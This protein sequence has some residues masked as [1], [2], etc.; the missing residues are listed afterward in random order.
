MRTYNFCFIVYLA[1]CIFCV[2]RVKAQDGPNEFNKVPLT[3]NAGAENR[4]QSVPVNLYTGIPSFSVPVYSYSHQ[5]GIGLNVSINYQ[6]GGGVKVNESPSAVGL[7]WRLDAGGSITRVV[8]G[9]PDE[10]YG[11]GFMDAP[12]IPADYRPDGSKYYYDSLDAEQ[13]VFQFNF[14]GRSGKFFIGKNKQIVTVPLS[15]LKITYGPDTAYNDVIGYD[16]SRIGSFCI[17]AEDGTKYLFYD[18]DWG[19]VDAESGTKDGANDVLHATAWYISKIIA[20]FGTDTINF[21]YSNFN[22]YSTILFPKSVQ[23]YNGTVSRAFAPTATQSIFLKK[24]SSITFPDKKIMTFEYDAVIDYDGQD[25]VLKRIKVSDSLFRFGYVLDWTG[26]G[27]TSLCNSNPYNTDNRAFLNGIRY[28]TTTAAK[29]GYSFTYN[30]PKYIH[31]GCT[32]DTLG[33][34]HDHWGF[35]NGIYNSTN[36]I[37]TVAGLYTGANRSPT[38]AAIASSLSSVTDPSG[39]TTNYIYENNDVL[40]YTIA[41]QSFSVNAASATQTSVS[42]SQLFNNL[43]TFKVSFSSTVSRSGAPI[44]SGTGSLI[45]TITSTDGL[46]TY[47]TDTLDLYEMFYTGAVSFSRNINN[48]SYLFKTSLVSGTSAP[49]GLPI[50]VSWSNLS[51]A[52]GNATITGGIR[53]KQVTHVDS[54]TGKVDTIATYRY[55][56]ADGKSS[57]FLGMEPSYNYPYLRTTINLSGT[58]IDTATTT[59]SSEPVSTLVNTQGSPVGYSRVE[60]IKG[61]IYHNLGKQVFEFTNLQDANSSLVQNTFPYVPVQQRDWAMGLPKKISIYDSLGT[62][63]QVTVNTYSYTAQKYNNSSFQCLKLGKSAELKNMI[64]GVFTEYSTGLKYWQESGRADLVTSIDTFFHPNNSTTITRKD[65][66]YDTNYNVS[67]ITTDYDK[68]RSLKLEQRMYY[69]YSYTIG[70]TIGKLRD[71]GIFT[72][73]SKESW[74]T[75]DAT[76]RMLSAS[77]TDLQQLPKKYITPLTIYALQATTPV[78]QSTI[79]T[80]N[81][82]S[83]IRN[84]SYLVA[85]QN[86]VTYDSVGHALEI[87]N[88]LSGQSNA[89]IMDYFNQY[90]VAKVSNARY[91]DIAY[92][93][94]ESD[95]KG[96]WNIPDSPRNKTNAITGKFSYD[97]AKGAI[98]KTGLTTSI[99]YIITYWKATGATVTVSGATGTTL[100]A[101][102]NGWSLYSQTLSGASSVSIS[103]TGLID[104]LRLYPKDANMVTT[105]FEPLVGQTSTCDANSTITY[106]EY[107]GLNRLVV[108]RDKDKNAIKKYAY[109]D[110]AIPNWQNTADPLFCATPADGKAY[111]KQQ[112]INPY[113]ATYGTFRNIVDHTDC[114]MCP[115]PC[116]PSPEIKSVNCVC[117][118][119]IKV[120]TS[121][122]YKKINGVF[123]WECTY[124]WCWSDHSISGNY[125]EV[126]ASSC[127]V[128]DLCAVD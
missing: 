7:G 118:T 22:E 47:S 109:Y 126:H 34:K 12:A 32:G 97:L 24:L 96:N 54:L 60:L 86:F 100:L 55:I 103:G 95:S 59:I 52:A 122:V 25:L 27:R 83:L 58:V 74:I 39:G 28:Y 21:T 85:Q 38:S 4:A 40:P 64:T 128:E 80:F 51:A 113:S 46:T 10:V 82:A 1:V 78:P 13:D 84:S 94:F 81:P 71:S 87:K 121:S 44:F 3:G 65:I 104:E 14:N 92:T 11:K 115:P 120:Y 9:M 19:S 29:S 48:G 108:I 67:K 8:R 33:N 30:S 63:K 116:S 20:P 26:A 6:G 61:T 111:R 36:T 17:T 18:T 98:T 119:G 93:S 43:H 88:S 37:P 57:G 50:T 101:Q 127:T 102:Q 76:P 5:S 15:K 106:Y 66:L 114:T 79:G 105:T 23:L 69:P 91:S 110:N 123:Q 125:T 72:L 16:T 62:L 41:A 117:E 49:S 73:V 68:T 35:Y 45:C 77:I 124:H 31:Y 107:D 2:P 90:P 89:V 99:T 75:G 42:L 56:Q 53:I 112:D 70:G